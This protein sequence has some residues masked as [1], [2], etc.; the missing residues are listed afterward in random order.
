MW[1]AI[2]VTWEL[3]FPI[4]PIVKRMSTYPVSCSL[5]KVKPGQGTVCLVEPRV[6]SVARGRKS[7]R[8]KGRTSRERNGGPRGIGRTRAA[9]SCFSSHVFAHTHSFVQR[10]RCSTCDANSGRPPTSCVGRPGLVYGS[11]VRIAHTY[12]HALLCMRLS[13]L[14]PTSVRTGRI[15]SLRSSKNLCIM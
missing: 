5:F 11:C 12:I 14:A 7:A 1:I 8:G 6:I 15:I 13:Q 3:L 2:R 10:Q 9:R 4:P